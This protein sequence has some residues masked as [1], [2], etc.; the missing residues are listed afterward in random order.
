MEKSQLYQEVLNELIEFFSHYQNLSDI[1]IMTTI[2]SVIHMKFPQLVFVGF[3]ITRESN[4]VKYLEVGPYQGKVLACAKIDIGNGVCGTAAQR[5]Q[6]IVV[7]DVNR[8]ETYIACDCASKSEIVVPVLHNDEVTSVLDID[9]DV[10]GYFTEVDK[11]WLE[12]IIS[13][14]LIN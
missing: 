2:S 1:A 14:F 7:E 13:S 5:K 6:T 12:R 4:A 8:F 9:S 3:Y 11:E 10:L